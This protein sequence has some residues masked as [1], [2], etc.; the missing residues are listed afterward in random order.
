MHL[1]IARPW[2]G[3]G[4]GGGGGGLLKSNSDVSFTLQ[5]LRYC[6]VIEIPFSLYLVRINA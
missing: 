5:L 4:G 2:G 6:V 1:L 3:G